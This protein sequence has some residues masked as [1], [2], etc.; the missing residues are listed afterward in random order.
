MNGTQGGNGIADS[1]AAP[2]NHLRGI[3]R[4]KRSPFVEALLRIAFPQ[5]QSFPVWNSKHSP[6]SA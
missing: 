4:C 3:R 2:L 6:A 1:P 5:R